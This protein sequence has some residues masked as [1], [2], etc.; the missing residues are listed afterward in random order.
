M[1]ET[2]QFWLKKLRK[3]VR[4]YEGIPSHDESN[5]CVDV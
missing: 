1:L 5:N 4:G 2:E 3:W